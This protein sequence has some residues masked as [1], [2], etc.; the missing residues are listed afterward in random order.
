MATA[1]Q[2]PPSYFRPV[3]EDDDFAQVDI[4]DLMDQ[5]AEVGELHR[6]PGDLVS[7]RGPILVNRKGWVEFGMIVEKAGAV[8]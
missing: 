7:H 2:K 6:L 8:V 5:V 4:A 1:L 3:T